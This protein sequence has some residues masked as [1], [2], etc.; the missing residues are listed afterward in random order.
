MGNAY[1][2]KECNDFLRGVIRRAR[3]LE[4]Q[5]KYGECLDYMERQLL[6]CAEVYGHSSDQ[7]MHLCEQFASNCNAF[8]ILAV[9]QGSTNQPTKLLRRAISSL[10]AHGTPTSS[11]RLL[12][13]AITFNNLGTHYRRIGRLRPSL[14]CLRQALKFEAKLG[15]P[16]HHADTHINLCATLSALAQHSDAATH[17]AKAVKLLKSELEAYHQG[18]AD[19]SATHMEQRA[20]VLA[21]AMHNH[22][23]ELEHLRLRDAAA[24]AY[25]QAAATAEMYFGPSHPTSQALAAA[26]HACQADE[27]AQP[28]TKP[29]SPGFRSRPSSAHSTAPSWAAESIGGSSSY[30]QIELDGNFSPRTAQEI[31]MQFRAPT[32]G[33]KTTK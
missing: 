11:R 30:E 25:H 7:A 15:E 5:C 8:A 16:E 22:G 13:L 26:Y 1:D 28:I 20:G 18:E 6:Y 14:G 31:P 33:N 4:K 17:A 29:Q 9:Q 24:K 23:V 10:R 21:V 2:G 19:H 3:R 32:V 12:I 27:A